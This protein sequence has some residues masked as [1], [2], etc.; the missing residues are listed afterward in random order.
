MR[1]SFS[2]LPETP[3]I[4]S[5]LFPVAF[6]VSALHLSRRVCHAAS[7]IMNPPFFFLPPSSPRL[8]TPRSPVIA[9]FIFHIAIS[10]HLVYLSD[11][12]HL[13]HFF[14]L[15]SSSP[16]LQFRFSINVIV[17]C[18]TTLSH[19][20]VRVVIPPPPPPPLPF[21]PFHRTNPF[22]TAGRLPHPSMQ[23]DG[24]L[25]L[26]L[27]PEVPSPVS[28][29]FPSSPRAVEFPLISRFFYLAAWVWRPHQL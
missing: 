7:F 9:Y 6:Y 19:A 21:C 13:Q 27:T 3:V 4:F 24:P 28:L 16:N 15:S 8:P 11:S 25:T 10:I 17:Y 12:P 22:A 29:P 20:V 1:F 23:T 2:S 26:P 18:R 14:P 5:I